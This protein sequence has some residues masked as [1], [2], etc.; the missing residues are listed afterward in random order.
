M[1]PQPEFTPE[2]E[3]DI[4]KEALAQRNPGHAIFH[5]SH[6]LSHQ[7]QNQEYLT[8]LNR[9]IQ[10]T[11]DPLTL[12]QT[13]ERGG[14]DFAN[15]AVRAYIHA[16]LNQYQEAIGLMSQILRATPVKQYLPW[17][18]EW[19]SRPERVDRVTAD[20]MIQLMMSIS[21]LF[22]D[23][24]DTAQN[25]ETIEKLFPAITR[26]RKQ[27]NQNGIFAGVSS[28]LWRKTGHHDEAVAIAQAGY[29]TTPE[30]MTAVFLGGALKAKGDLQNAITSFKKALEYRPED[31]HIRMDIADNLCKLG[32]VAEGLDYYQHV[33]NSDPNH[34]WAKPYY[35]FY[36]ARLT[37]EQT[38][39]DQLDAYVDANP[40]NT[41]AANLLARLTRKPYINFLPE[42]ADATINVLKQISQQNIDG[43]TQ[44]AVNCLESPSARLALDLYMSG[45]GN[46]KSVKVGVAEIQKPDP[47]YPQRD[48]A[49]L[50]W[51]YDGVDPL[52]AVNPPSPKIAQAIS[53]IA[54]QPFHITKW[55]SLA[56]RLG[57][58]SDPQSLN[59]LLGVMVHP[60]ECPQDIPLWIWIQHVQ[61]AAALTIAYI[62]NSW[63]DS[64][65][66]KA[67]FSLALGPM[68]WS[69]GAAVLAL[70]QIALEEPQ[71][72][73]EILALFTQIF[74][75]LP[76]PGAIPYI[77]T[78]VLC[79]L[80]M[81]QLDAK[82]RKELELL[83]DTFGY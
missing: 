26:S 2:Q 78:L 76:R 68:D 49:Y 41:E 80:R 30:Y 20:V 27:H 21:A 7:P 55:S 4:A 65:R 69:V 6:A 74:G 19:L 3:F 67:L 12:V 66:K 81:P 53:A 63:D 23:F 43:I 70:T 38:W 47:R 64:L 48:V 1:N 11:R 36:Q 10:N 29:E 77:D 52:P 5:L 22:G 45:K 13:D 9:I 18:A 51:K 37:N 8:L 56:R 60:P 33:L 42:P 35:L 54:A 50:L 72:E 75:N 62:D 73:A 58:D 40:T 39:V 31:I 71:T 15:A 25:K 82:A 24:V 44:L 28:I 34:P 59:D 46:G 16:Q 83:Q 14:M 57:A 61:V 79:L 17:V 32:E